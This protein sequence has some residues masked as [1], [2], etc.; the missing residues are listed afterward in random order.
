ML[1]ALAQLSNSPLAGGAPLT[2]STP[3]G[4]AWPIVH[5]LVEPPVSGLFNGTG[6]SAEA[7]EALAFLQ[8]HQPASD[9]AS[10]NE[11]VLSVG[12]RHA[13]EARNATAWA[14]AVPWE[15]FLNDVLPYA[16][17]NE[18]RDNWRPLF[19]QAFMP[20]VRHTN[21]TVEAVLALNAHIW[22]Q[23]DVQYEEKLS[24]HITA[25]LEAVAYKRASCTG[26]SV[27]LVDAC[28][29]VG[30]PARMALVG[31]WAPPNSGNHNWVEVWV[32][33]QLKDSA[34][35]PL[36]SATWLRRGATRDPE[37][38]RQSLLRVRLAALAG[39][40]LPWEAIA[41]L[42]AQPP[43]P[44]VLERAAS[45]VADPC[46]CPFTL[47]VDDHWEFT[48]AFDGDGAMMNKTWFTERVAA[49]DPSVPSQRVFATTW[50]PAAGGLH[51]PAG[52]DV[53]V[54]GGPDASP[55][56]AIDRTDYYRAVT[57]PGEDYS[58]GTKGGKGPGH[59]Y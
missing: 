31:Q 33:P 50:K 11:D 3:R 21:S 27:L 40:A 13:L 57:P 36:G 20:L 12:V 7:A 42:G 6:W 23:L 34:S 51:L 2:P 28:R 30:V 48:G 24:P 25:P 46:L 35:P 39:S 9:A 17:L 1:I 10:L 59:I 32:R 58:E 15:I 56:N 53:T 38:S 29:A 54:T 55:V 41:P 43:L 52:V 16:V 4:R 47:Q 44:R 8:E 45:E 22:D 5:S 26:L 37:E 18:A 49:Q 14:R 19:H